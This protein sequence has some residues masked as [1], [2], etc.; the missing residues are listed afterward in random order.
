MSAAALHNLR[1]HSAG[2]KGFLQFSALHPSES[3]HKL[4]CSMICRGGQHT[5]HPSKLGAAAGDQHLRKEGPAGAGA[6]ASKAAAGSMFL[7]RSLISYER[8]FHLNGRIFEGSAL[9]TITCI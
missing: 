5:L 8:S 3:Q 1:K 7:L 4:I 2:E 6:V 9:S